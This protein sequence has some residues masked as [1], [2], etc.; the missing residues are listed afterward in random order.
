MQR[1]LFN[2]CVQTD[3]KLLC[4]KLLWF[5]WTPFDS[6]CKQVRFRASRNLSSELTALTA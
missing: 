2:F 1:N 6:S 4:F 3:Q 5:V